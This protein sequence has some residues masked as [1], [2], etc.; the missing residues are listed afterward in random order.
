MEGRALLRIP[1]YARGFCLPRICHCVLSKL[2]SAYG[3]HCH[4]TYLVPVL[5][6]V[7]S[8]MKCAPFLKCQC[9][10]PLRRCGHV[11]DYGQFGGNGGGPYIIAV[12]IASYGALFFPILMCPLDIPHR[13]LPAMPDVVPSLTASH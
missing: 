4:L 1:D 12:H 9:I 5:Q 7:D 3:S 10:L 2:R 11:V 8:D 13:I 6:H